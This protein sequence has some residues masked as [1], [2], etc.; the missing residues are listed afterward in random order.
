MIC[1]WLARNQNVSHVSLGYIWLVLFAVTFDIVAVNHNYIFFY[2][3][4]NNK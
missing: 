1:D 2:E 3:Q 4:M